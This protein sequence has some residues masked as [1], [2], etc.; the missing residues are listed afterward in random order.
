MKLKDL[1]P[2]EFVRDLALSYVRKCERGAIVSVNEA[3]YLVEVY[4]KYA[5]DWD[6]VGA[7]DDDVQEVTGK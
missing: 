4:N 2:V 1:T 6:I 3:S 7:T 5:D